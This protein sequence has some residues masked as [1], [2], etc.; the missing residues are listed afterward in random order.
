MLAGIF[1]V[2]MDLRT[3]I[4][5]FLSKVGQDFK[6]LRGLWC[7]IYL[8]FYP[9]LVIYCVTHFPGSVNTAITVTGGV[10]GT[11]FSGYVIS[12]SIEKSAEVKAQSVPGAIPAVKE[13]INE[14]T[15]NLP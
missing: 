14:P 8:T 10:V 12:R 15:T 1:S 4:F 7:W 13:P 9:L 11:I 6:S 2:L 3:Y 5:G